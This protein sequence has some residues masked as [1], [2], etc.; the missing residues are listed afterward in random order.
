MAVAVDERAELALDGVD[1]AVLGVLGILDADAGARRVLGVD[2]AE[3]LGVAFALADA[4]SLGSAETA[5]LCCPD[6]RGGGES[7]SS[8][9]MYESSLSAVRSTIIAPAAGVADW[10]RCFLGV[11]GDTF[12]TTGAMGLANAVSLGWLI[13]T[14]PLA[15]R[16][17]ETFFV[18]DNEG[19]TVRPTG[20]EATR[21]ELLAEALDTE[22]RGRPGRGAVA[23][24]GGPVATLD[25]RGGRGGTGGGCEYEGG[26]WY[27]DGGALDPYPPP[28]GYPALP[29][30]CPELEE[31]VYD[32]A[33]YED[34]VLE[35][36]RSA[37]GCFR[38]GGE[39]RCG[40]EELLGTG[41]RG[42]SVTSRRSKLVPMDIM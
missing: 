19:G 40:S 6:R 18:G 7:S 29:D 3:A 42:L 39:G 1:A 8:E 21:A 24:A 36:G 35:G 25:R 31:D 33:V 32:D 14:K 41:G 27:A 11:T 9:G 17:G 22:G 13:L 4:C 26:C 20:A 37:W 30:R 2:V 34:E 15:G 10:D 38:R 16:E 28:E 5:R 23:G 12:G